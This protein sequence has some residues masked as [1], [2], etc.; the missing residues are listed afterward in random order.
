MSL[1]QYEAFVK[2][3]E[4]GS[5]TRAAAALGYTQSGVSHMLQNLESELGFTVLT[6]SRAGIRLTQEGERVLPC[7][8]A[9]LN[10]EEQMQQVVSSIQGMEMGRVRIGAFTSVAVHWLPALIKGFQELYP[11]IEFE[12]RNGDYYDVENWLNAG[13]V[14][15]GFV[16]MPTT[17]DGECIPLMQ[18]RLLAILPQDHPLA[19]ELIFPVA[20][21]EKEDFISL[22]HQSDHDARRVLEA[23]GLS[24]KVKF[25]TK[26]DYQM[27]AMV[28]YGL[29]VSIVPELLLE[30]RDYRV[31]RLELE[32]PSQ[33]VIGLAIP[34]AGALNPAARNFRDYI[35]QWMGEKYL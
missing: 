18:D 9:I 13:E 5:L 20:Q 19:E 35:L 8:R 26:D 17:V 16:T 23:S 29:G 30:G 25:Y 7:I 28:E 32:P 27:I 12:L 22:E 11:G 14:D 34:N 6:R 4:L 33:R 15:M 2:V 21:F 31:A 10:A 3:V 24:P 1:R